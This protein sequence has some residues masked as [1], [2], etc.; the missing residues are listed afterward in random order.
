MAHPFHPPCENSLVIYIVN[1]LFPVLMPLRERV[2]RV[3]IEPKEWQWLEG[4]RDHR[5]LLLANHPSETEPVIT[6]WLARKLGQPFNYVATHELFH[7]PTGW[8]IRCMGAFS[9][10]R[11]RPDRTSLRMSVRLLAE[12][13]RKLVIF[14][15]GETHMEN[16]RILPLNQGAIQ[17]GFWTLERLEELGKPISL[18]IIPVVIKYRYIGDP[19]PSLLRGMGRLERDLGLPAE[20]SMT[21]RER[22]R[23]AGL[24]VLAGVEQE[25][26]TDPPDP[27][28]PAASVDARIAA[29]Y[30]LIASR[31]AQ[32]LH[33]SPPTSSVHLGMRSLFNATFDYLE[34]LAAGRTRYERRLHTRRV[35]AARACLNDLWR[36][37]N[38]MVISEEGMSATNAERAGEALWR[39]E[40]EVCGRPRTRPLREAVVRLGTPLELAERLPAYRADRKAA[41]AQCTTEVEE[42]LRSLLGSLAH[43]GT[44]PG[45]G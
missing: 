24:A 12:R 7:G 21:L 9:I 4:L 42:R 38:F 3:C 26:G 30:Q 31:V 44:P 20:P 8:L 39:L 33:V 19:L 34:G 2:V 6:G 15:E 32:V 35:A 5:A 1:L 11:G 23:R 10:L 45:S 43:P 17:I 18:P 22:V 36:V 37:Q 16:D 27:G 13:D 40:R 25:Y 14:P 41:V 29:L 28:D